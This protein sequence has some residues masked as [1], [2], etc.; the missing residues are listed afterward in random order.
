VELELVVVQEWLPVGTFKS[1]AFSDFMTAE[2]TSG[3]DECPIKVSPRPLAAAGTRG[4]TLD[5]VEC[6]SRLEFD[7]RTISSQRYLD[8]R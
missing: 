8:S 3:G 2:V 7:S 5:R 1:R 6:A 4:L